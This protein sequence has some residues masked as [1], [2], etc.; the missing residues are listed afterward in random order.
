[1]TK[2]IHMTQPMATDD[3]ASAIST[4]PLHHPWT[5][6]HSMYAV[7]GGFAI[8]TSNTETRYLPNGRQSMTL[9]TK[10]L[11]FIA[12]YDPG[13]LPNI[14][15]SEVQDKSKADTFSKALTCA[16]AIWLCTQVL[17]RLPYDLATSILEMNTAVHALCALLLYLMYWLNKPLDVYIATPCSSE[18][19]RLL[20]AIMAAHF[21]SPQS[22]WNFSTTGLF[23]GSSTD[24]MFPELPRVSLA[25]AIRYINIE[26]LLNLQNSAFV[27][28]IFLQ[29][30][31]LITKVGQP[32]CCSQSKPQQAR[33]M[34]LRLYWRCGL[35]RPQTGDGVIVLPT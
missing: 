9:A 13:L 18:N 16:Q 7:M 33:T 22:T 27:S 26:F 25:L 2:Y 4:R 17:A 11:K 30:K 23:S 15:E 31:T 29:H 5:M 35:R 8:D 21:A 10:G 6:T 12:K 1:M 32:R 20:G 28:L 19:L 34:L 3:S 24:M 14:L